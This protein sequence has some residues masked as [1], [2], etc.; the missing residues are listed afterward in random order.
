MGKRLRRWHHFLFRGC[1]RDSGDGGRAH[2]VAGNSSQDILR[3]GSWVLGECIGTTAA[4]G[5]GHSSGRASAGT[6]AGA[7][8]LR[9]GISSSAVAHGGSTVAFGGKIGGTADRRLAVSGVGSV[10]HGACAANGDLGGTSHHIRIRLG[11]P[12]ATSATEEDGTGNEDEASNTYTGTDTSLGT[13]RESSAILAP[14]AAIA[15]A[16]AGRATAGG[17]GLGAAV[18]LRHNESR[19]GL[20]AGDGCGRFGIGLAG[21]GVGAGDYGGCNRSRH[22]VVSDGDNSNGGLD[23]HCS[24]GCLGGTLRQLGGESGSGSRG[25]GS[26]A[27]LVDL[28]CC[29]FPDGLCGDVRVATGDG[30]GYKIRARGGQDSDSGRA[31][32]GGA[33][34][35]GIAGDG[36]G[37]GDGGVAAAAAAAGGAAGSRARGSRRG[38]RTG[39]AGTR[40]SRASRRS[41]SCRL[42][43]TA[44]NGSVGGGG[45]SRDADKQGKSHLDKGERMD[46]GSAPMASG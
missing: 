14:I 28:D 24:R 1:W 34:R 11:G 31:N 10:R 45:K 35:F 21:L 4:S 39:R 40:R 8:R 30:D 9:L 23:S 19:H 16:A 37:Y 22:D 5:R 36:L 7:V 3:A 15:A 29:S 32:G 46:R 25:R 42:L 12:V 17:S 27:A 26:N 18:G 41:R 44:D 2:V 38:R 20:G 6:V 43:L 13:S 33:G